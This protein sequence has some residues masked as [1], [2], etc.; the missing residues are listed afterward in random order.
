MFFNKRDHARD[1][2][3]DRAGS[4]LVRAAGLSE[5]ESDTAASS[6]FLYARIRARIGQLQRTEQSV[7]ALM[8]VSIAWRAVPALAL[9]A[10]VAVSALLATKPAAP[11]GVQPALCKPITS[12]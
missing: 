7:P 10:L 1:D 5:F 11:G 9:V 3:L 2:R 6:P 12:S 8:M 4:E